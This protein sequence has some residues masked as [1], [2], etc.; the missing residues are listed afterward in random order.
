ML[1]VTLVYYVYLNTNDSGFKSS[2]KSI[3]LTVPRRCFFCE[4]LLSVMLHVGV[5]C[6]MV[7]VPCRLVV[8]C[9]ERAELLAVVFCNFPKC[10]LV[11]SE[12]RA[13]LAL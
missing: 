13:W 10:V 8:T 2:S 12:L 1:L 4:S 3:L 6:A 9:S 11:P 7:S 5:F